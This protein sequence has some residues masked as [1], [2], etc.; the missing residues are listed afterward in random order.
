MVE[1]REF[2]KPLLHCVLKSSEW[3]LMTLMPFSVKLLNGYL[4]YPRIWIS[5]IVLLS[6]EIIIYQIFLLARLVK[7]RHVTKY[8]PALKRG[9]SEWSVLRKL[10]E[11]K[12]AKICSRICRW[13]LS[14]PRICSSNLTLPL[15]ALG[16]LFASRKR[17]MTADKHP[18][19]LSCQM[20]AIVY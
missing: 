20:E 12:Y 15:H 9:I 17:S 14:V 19:I 8:S 18:S 5:Q 10:F 6:V 13:I 7:T 11:G 3:Q 16:K 4:K 2:T 1:S